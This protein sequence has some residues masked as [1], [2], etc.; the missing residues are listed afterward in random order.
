MLEKVLEEE[1]VVGSLG[2]YTAPTGWILD[3]FPPGNLVTSTSQYKIIK[4]SLSWKRQ[5]VELA[6][7][8]LP[9]DTVSLLPSGCRGN[10][11]EWTRCAY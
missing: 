5:Q 8:L 11:G 9:D 6:I 2:V 1:G 3:L 4:N 10:T 7:Q